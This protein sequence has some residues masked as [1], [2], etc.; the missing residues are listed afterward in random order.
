MAVYFERYPGDAYVDIL[1]HDNYGDFNKIETPNKGVK[2]LED[3]TDEAQKRGKVAAL[4]ETGLEKIVN[5]TWY[6]ANLLNQLKSSPK[7]RRIAYLMVWRNAHPGHFYA[8]YPDH[9]SV[10]DFMQFYND[11]LT[12]FENDQPRLYSLPTPTP[13]AS[14]QVK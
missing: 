10:P 8:P 12:T 4:T 3:L 6:T 5:L 11:P 9:A 2:T 1:G 7:A 13:R 14:I